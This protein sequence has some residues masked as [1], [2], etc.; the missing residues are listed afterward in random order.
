MKEKN[1]FLDYKPRDHFETP[2]PEN[3]HGIL[4]ISEDRRRTRFYYVFDTPVFFT[5][6]LVKLIGRE[7][8][9]DVAKEII[10]ELQREVK[11]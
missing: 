2:L 8:E 11:K 9:I 6:M 5:Q 1:I 10:E 7:I 4:E 3:V